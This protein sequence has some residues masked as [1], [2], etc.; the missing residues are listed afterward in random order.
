MKLGDIER[1]VTFANNARMPEIF[2]LSANYL[3]TAD[4][5][6][7]PE[8]MKYIITFYVKGKAFDKLVE[9]YE[10]CASNEIDEYRDYEKA[11]SALKDG[12]KYASKITGPEKEDKEKSIKRKLIFVDKF[13]EARSLASSNPEE[14]LKICTQLL[15]NVIS[16]HYI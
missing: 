14:M 4:W 9:F 13:I 5:H 15:N 10:T 12:F 7:N 6:K 2:I 11:L 1:V 8:L 3:Q 16:I